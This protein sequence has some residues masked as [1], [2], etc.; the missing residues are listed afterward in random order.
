MQ[1]DKYYGQPEE[2]LVIKIRYFCAMATCQHALALTDG[3]A[4]AAAAAA[5]ARVAT[6]CSMTCVMDSLRRRL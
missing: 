6:A 3:T 1:H 2:T 5:A 4:A